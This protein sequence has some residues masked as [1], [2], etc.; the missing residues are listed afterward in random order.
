MNS[1]LAGCVY[2]FDMILRVSPDH[3]IRKVQPEVNSGRNWTAEQ[4]V[5]EAE[6]SE[7]LNKGHRWW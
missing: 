2:H 7:P 1:R 5:T 3:V 4:A 6:V